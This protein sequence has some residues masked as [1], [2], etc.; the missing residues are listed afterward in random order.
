VATFTINH[1]PWTSGMPVPFVVAIIAL[2][3]QA[4]LHLTS[5]V[6]NCAAEDVFIGQRVRAVFEQHSDVWLPLFE[7]VRSL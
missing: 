5:N 6:I 4:A 2:D 7:P 1:Q 3:E